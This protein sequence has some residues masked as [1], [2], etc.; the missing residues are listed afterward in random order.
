MA[1]VK[2]PLLSFAAHNTIGNSI[3]FQSGSR[4]TIARTKPIPSDPKSPA[5]LIQRQKYRDAVT[6]WNALSPGE[7]EDWRGVCR[8]LTAYQCF[9]KNE[10]KYIPPPPPPVEY[11]EE[12]IQYDALVS[13]KELT[14]SRVGQELTITNRKVIKLGFWLSK[15]NAPNGNVTFAIR[16]END[17]SAIVS[18]L[19]G[20]A[21]AL[22]VTPT[23]KEV[24]FDTPQTINE[25]VRICA[26]FSGGDVNNRVYLSQ[27]N[28]DVK[29]SEYMVFYYNGTWLD[30]VATDAAYIYTYFLP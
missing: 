6:A 22:T 28:S 25:L 15:L 10:L 26:Q 2:I 21:A 16:K 7:K 3:T 9:I 5:Q 13:I 4:Q 18:K 24:E 27:Q 29:A 11:T 12:Q 8:G 1:K 20:D 14:P 19:W 17:D 23:Y 30:S